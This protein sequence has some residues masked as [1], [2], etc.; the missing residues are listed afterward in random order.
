M[1]INRLKTI[2]PLLLADGATSLADVAALNAFAGVIVEIGCSDE[3]L[4]CIAGLARRSFALLARVEPVNRLSNDELNR[5][6]GHGVG[7]IVL[8]GCRGRADIQ[9]LD[10]MLQAAE[11]ARGVPSDRTRLYVEYGSSAES[12]LS[13]HTLAGSSQRLEALIFDGAALALS[14]GCNAPPAEPG[15]AV[16]APILA[17]RAN[18]VLRASEA[19][20][21]AYEMLPATCKD[22]AAARLALSQSRDNGF[23]SVVCHTIEQAAFVRGA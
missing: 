15:A 12:L 2:R 20:I 7:G 18:V 9:K 13:P 23:V 3:T 5:L 22:E 16:A 6:L 19:G 10:V 4:L 17:A 14:I 11:A 21:P 1:S 8:S